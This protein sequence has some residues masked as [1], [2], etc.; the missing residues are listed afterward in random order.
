[1]NEKQLSHG[2]HILHIEANLLAFLRDSFTGCLPVDLTNSA[3]IP[4]FLLHERPRWK[5]PVKF[6]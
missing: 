5:L 6:L 1:M 3:Y 4:A 2:I